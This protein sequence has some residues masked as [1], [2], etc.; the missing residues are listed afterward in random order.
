[1]KTDRMICLC[2]ATS[3]LFNTRWNPA[4]AAIFF[5]KSLVSP[6]SGNMVCLKASWEIW[7]RKKVWSLRWSAALCNLT[8]EHKKKQT[9]RRDSHDRLGTEIWWTAWCVI[10]TISRLK[11]VSEQNGRSDCVRLLE[12]LFIFLWRPGIV[13]SSHGVGAL[14]Q[15]MRWMNQQDMVNSKQVANV[16]NY[17]IPSVW[18]AYLWKWSNLMCLLHSMSGF[19]VLPLAYSFNR[20]LEE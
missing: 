20:L 11:S 1:M 17:Y 7:L 2:R 12:N 16:C 10:H 18:M 9:G 4:S 14:G 13:A 19:G 8:A 5:T 15:Q 6:A 3:F